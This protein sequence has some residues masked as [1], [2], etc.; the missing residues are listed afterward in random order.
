M[1]PS[2]DNQSIAEL[3]NEKEN[4]D[5][6]YY[7]NNLDQECTKSLCKNILMETSQNGYK[8]MHIYFKAF[9]R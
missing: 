8:N 7:F 6:I 9:S 3:R 1:L 2:Q 5:R 4:I